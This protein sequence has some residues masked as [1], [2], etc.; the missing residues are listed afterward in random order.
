MFLKFCVVLTMYKDIAPLCSPTF[1]L[2]LLAVIRQVDKSVKFNA[3]VLRCTDPHEPPNWM[4]MCTCCQHPGVT[5]DLADVLMH[6]H[7]SWVDLQR[8]SKYK[9]QRAP[10][11]KYTAVLSCDKTTRIQ[12]GWYVECSVHCFLS[13]IFY[14]GQRISNNHCLCSYNTESCKIAYFNL[15]IY[16]SAS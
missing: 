2:F 1:P 15:Y 4:I 14:N 6:Y 3:G 9:A 13:I 11:P 7:Y 12:L 5:I 8:A 16:I 10:A